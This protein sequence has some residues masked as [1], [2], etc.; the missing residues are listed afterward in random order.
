MKLLI[1]LPSKGRPT[2]LQALTGSWL[3]E[4]GLDCKIL[5]EPQDALAYGAIAPPGSIL[6]LTDD[7]RG[8]EFALFHGK[9]YALKNG[10]DVIFKIDD[11]IKGW[12]T[13]DKKDKKTSAERFKQ[14][15][16]D[17]VKP[18]ENP[19]CAGI[20]FGY[21][22]EFWHDKKWFGVNHR[23]QT[24]YLVK[25]EHFQ[26]RLF[27]KGEKTDDP[28]EDFCNFLRVIKDGHKVLRYGRYTMDTDV[29]TGDGGLQDWYRNQTP[30][31]YKELI[32]IVR[33]EFPWLPFRKKPDG[34][35]EPDFNCPA[36]NGKKLP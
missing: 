35:I 21:R 23:F 2:Q 6:E 13:M 14:L 25:T 29:G 30:E 19:N 4:Q 11:D 12:S 8:T 22:Q 5:V 27:E 9:Q 16:E 20:S 36:V 7:N 15:L 24:C 26:P 31:R 32:E 1:L 28:W 34:R 17:V 18:L 3:F 10:Y 33:K